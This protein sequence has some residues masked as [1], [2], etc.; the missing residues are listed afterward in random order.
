MTGSKYKKDIITLV[1]NCINRI[2]PGGIKWEMN[3][4]GISNPTACIRHSMLIARLLLVSLTSCFYLISPPQSPLGIKIMVVMA[5][6]TAVLLTRNLYGSSEIDDILVSIYDP[7]KIIGQQDPPA[8]EN[9]KPYLLLT[10]IT[11]EVMGTALVTMPTGGLDSPFVWYALSPI[12]AAAFYLPFYYSWLT[13]GLFLSVSLILRYT[14][15]GSSIPLTLELFNHSSL[16]MIFCLCTALAQLAAALYRKL[17]LAYSELEKA[18]ADSENALAHISSL[19]QVLEA[20]SAGEDRAQMANVL[21]AYTAKLCGRP[22]ACFIVRDNGIWGKEAAA[23][24]LLR[25]GGEENPLSYRIWEEEVNLIWEQIESKVDHSDLTWETAGGQRIKYQPITS[26]GECFG[27]LAYLDDG[28]SLPEKDNADGR[29]SL[30]F[31]AGLGGIALERLETDKLWGRL[32]ISEEQ[33]RIANEIHD[34]VAQY[35]FSMV[36]AVHALSQQEFSLRDNRVQQQ[37]KLLE[38]TASRAS[39]ELKASIYGLSPLR[40]GESIFVENIASYLDSLGQLHGIQVDLQT[41]GNEEAISP[42][43]RK[44]LYRMVREASSNAIRHGKCSRL[45]VRLDMYPGQTRLEIEDNGCGWKFR[46]IRSD[47]KAGLGLRNMTH[48]AE[49]F[50]GELNIQSGPGKGTTIRCIIPKPVAEK[51]QQEPVY[52]IGIY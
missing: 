10:I 16:I 52:K 25:L 7:C 50:H 15:L 47:E 19:Y 3:Q 36:C 6:I 43:L 31:L 37:L 23:T 18:H 41:E 51:Q 49:I 12:I 4:P 35:L 13:T 29:E 32:L 22:S 42:A 26:S 2:I 9:R 44:A 48:T 33:N 39:R 46:E 27:V 24:R 45:R 17:A 34:G 40:R 11:I 1:P 5:M 38:D 14:L 28:G 8:S 21:A 30:S 20:C